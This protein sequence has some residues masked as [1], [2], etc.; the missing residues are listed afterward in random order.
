LHVAGT[1]N[2]HFLARPK[3][4]DRAGHE[5]PQPNCEAARHPGSA[6]VTS[7]FAGRAGAGLVTLNQPA[8][9][10]FLPWKRNDRKDRRLVEVG[11]SRFGN[12]AAVGNEADDVFGVARQR[13]A[14]QL[15]IPRHCKFE[16][17]TAAQFADEIRRP[18]H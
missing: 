1:I 4:S 16:V 13:A 8:Q 18:F 9:K 17:S 10:L 3:S 7:F 6:R 11:V 12:E 2:Q 14:Q 15:G 5:Q